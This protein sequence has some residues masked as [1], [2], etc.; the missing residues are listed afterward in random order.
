MVFFFFIFF[1]LKKK[2]QDFIS[3]GLLLFNLE[4]CKNNVNT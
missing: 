2:K 3:Y 4:D 1:P